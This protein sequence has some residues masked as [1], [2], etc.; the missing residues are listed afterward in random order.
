MIEYGP[1]QL[2][3]KAKGEEN[4]CFLILSKDTD[5][6]EYGVFIEPENSYEKT[7]RSL[8][9]D[10][11][12]VLTVLRL[13]KEIDKPCAEAIAEDIGYLNEGRVTDDCEYLKDSETVLE[14]LDKLLLKKPNTI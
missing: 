9:K 14:D 3:D 6:G 7:L 4:K 11:A 2:K 5:S 8:E 13:Y 1:E 10:F 12:S